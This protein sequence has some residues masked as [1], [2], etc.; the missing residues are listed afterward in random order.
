MIDILKILLPIFY[1]IAVWIYGK[2]FFK[3]SKSA[4]KVKSTLLYIVI[5]IHFIYLILRTVTFSHPPI[6]KIFEIFSVVA[7]SISFAYAYIELKTKVK[8]TGYFILMVAF[9]FQ[10]ISSIFIKDLLVVPDILRSNLLGFHVT[11]ALLG[12]SAIT[13]SAIYGMLYLMLYHEIKTNRF[14]IIYQR[15][16]NLEILEKM[17]L[18]AT[19]FGFVLLTV[20]IVVGLVWLPK[21]FETFSYA[22]PK[23]IGTVFIWVLYAT[24]LAAN[25]IARWQGKR[26]VWLSILG[27]IVSFFSMTIV[28]MFFTGFH[29]F[30]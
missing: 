12:F 7:F 8:G 5:L 15:L 24:G 1:F 29:K 23:L 30:H 14:G 6:T 3:S 19:K 11:S 20:A 4:E 21:A 26:I 2:A 17:S 28:N 13:I 10:L 18:T 22:D 16:P 25:K 27:F 9:F